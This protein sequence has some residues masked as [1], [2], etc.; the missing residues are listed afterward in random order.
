[1]YQWER[2]LEDAVLHLRALTPSP[3]R[4]ILLQ[5]PHYEFLDLKAERQRTSYLKDKLNKVLAKEMAS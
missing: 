1:M 3:L 2:L 5:V 4:P